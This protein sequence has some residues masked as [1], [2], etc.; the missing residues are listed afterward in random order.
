MELN[1]SFS[2]MK[3]IKVNSKGGFVTMKK[4][5]TMF[6]VILL[7]LSVA[8]VHAKSK[9]TVKKSKATV[10]KTVEKN[11]QPKKAAPA[12][13]EKSKE[14]APETKEENLNAW[15]W[16]MKKMSQGG[17]F[18]WFIFLAGI[19]AMIVSIERV[20]ALYFRFAIN[21]KAFWDIIKKHVMTNNVRQAITTCEAKSS[22]ALPQILKAA[23]E[24]SEG[25]EREIQDAVDEAAL[26]VVPTLQKNLPY[27]SMIANIATLLGLLGTILGLIQAFKS[28]AVATNASQKSV[29][30][31]SGISIAMYTT[32]FGLI[33]A[34]PT[35][36]IFT[37]LQSKANTILEDIDLYSVKLINLLVAKKGGKV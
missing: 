5:L 34:I 35:L 30:L 20:F 25:T 33:V 22:A 21:G 4:F 11:S 9:K 23:L 1:W 37:I 16:F 3:V 18:M 19:F 31:A 17:L 13:V 24:K 26:E 28:L 7:M 15:Q 2:G 10:T 29:M 27:I 12:K 8:D 32:A 36:I 14:A 6:V